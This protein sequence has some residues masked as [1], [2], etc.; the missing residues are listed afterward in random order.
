MNWLLDRRDRSVASSAQRVVQ[1]MHKDLEYHKTR[2]G[3][4]ERTVVQ[5]QEIAT[6]SLQEELFRLEMRRKEILL[7]L[8]ETDNAILDRRNKLEHS[9]M[10]NP[11]KM[12]A[13]G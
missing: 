1:D 4:L 13:I 8:E 3:E 12:Q 5:L 11:M 9:R 10:I 2:V 6:K 7:E